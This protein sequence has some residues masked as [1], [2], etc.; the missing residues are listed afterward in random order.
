MTV[1]RVKAKELR[2]TDRLITEPDRGDRAWPIDRIQRK[3]GEKRS[4]QVSTR[5]RGTWNY[6]P[7]DLVTVQEGGGDR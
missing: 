4:V 2:I 5:G 3:P 7:D 1:R 6:A